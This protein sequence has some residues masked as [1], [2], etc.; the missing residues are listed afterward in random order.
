MSRAERKFR[1]AARRERQASKVIEAHAQL[2]THAVRV[3]EEMKRELTT[4]REVQV[5]FRHVLFGAFLGRAL[6]DETKMSD[7]IMAAW[8]E[9]FRGKEEAPWMAFS[10]R[11]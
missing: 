6:G 8:P 5:R 9:W 10:E 11:S 4:L 3:M 7:A 1:A 2:E